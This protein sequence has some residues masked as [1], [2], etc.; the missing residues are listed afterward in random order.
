MDICIDMSKFGIATI[1]KTSSDK[2]EN[3][4]HHFENDPDHLYGSGIG[5]IGFANFLQSD[6]TETDNFFNQHPRHR[7]NF[8]KR[9]ND[10][11]DDCVILASLRSYLDKKP[12][13]LFNPVMLELSEYSSPMI[14]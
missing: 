2:V 3:Y 4:M 12:I 13:A 7:F 9:W 5:K 11:M 14:S 10:F 8:P 6:L 1:V